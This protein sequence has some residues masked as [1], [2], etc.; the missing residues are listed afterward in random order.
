FL[1]RLGSL[2][3]DAANEPL[4]SDF[5][6]RFTGVSTDY[7]AMVHEKKYLVLKKLFGS[8]INRLTSLLIE[9]CERRKRYRDYTRHEL[10]NMLR[11]VIACFPVYRTYV[12]AEDGQVSE[13]DTAHINQ[14]IEAAKALRPDI[15]DD[16]LDFLRDLLLLRVR[17]TLESQLV[18]RFQQHTG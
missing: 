1:N 7:L 17:G 9:V 5:Y 14:A 15:D 16:L 18:M 13:A 2:L 6:T 12:R 10:S 11:E 3:I 8:D 4:I